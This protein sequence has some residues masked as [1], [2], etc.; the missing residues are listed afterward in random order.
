MYPAYK[1]GD[2]VGI[3]RITD[4][5]VISFGQPHVLV[6]GEQ[7]LIKYLWHGRKDGFWTLKSENPKFE[8]FEISIKKVI[9]LFLV[10]GI[11][12]IETM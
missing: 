9:H 12:R 7:R 8:E 1:R 6:T 3:K 10:K 11:V 4:F 5:A 2:M